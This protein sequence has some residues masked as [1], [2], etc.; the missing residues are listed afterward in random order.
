MP[1]PQTLL[2]GVQSFGNEPKV[3]ESSA[4]ALASSAVGV[5]PPRPVS[6]ITLPGPATIPQRPIS[7][8]GGILNSGQLLPNVSYPQPLL[9][10]GTSYS[11]YG[12]IYPQATPLQQVAQALKQSP[13]AV[14][15]TVASTTVTSTVPKASTSSTSL[16]EKQPPQKRKFQELP[17]GSRGPAKIDQVSMN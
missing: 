13:S 6:S 1:P 15:C 16:K 9:T 12:G 10:G 14:T 7:S 5:T 17:A 8:A 3:N 4:S 2:T 11:G